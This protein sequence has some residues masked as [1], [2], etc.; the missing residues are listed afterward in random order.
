MTPDQYQQAK[1][2]REMAERNRDLTGE[3]A[4]GLPAQGWGCEEGMCVPARLQGRCLQG[5]C[6]P[7]PGAWLQRAARSMRCARRPRI[8]PAS[9]DSLARMVTTTNCPQLLPA[10]N[11]SPPLL[12]PQMRS[13][14]PAC[15][16]RLR[17]TRWCRH[18]PATWPSARRRARPWRRPRPLAP[19]HCTRWAAAGRLAV[20]RW[21][22]VNMGM[23]PGPG[24]ADH[25]QISSACAGVRAVALTTCMFAAACCSAHGSR[26]GPADARP[27][28]D[29]RHRR[30]RR[31]LCRSPPSWATSSSSRCPPS[32]RAC[33][34]SSRRTWP[35][36]A[37]S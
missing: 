36:L 5:A 37:S 33:P 19:R 8:H 26:R 16:G 31:H 27:A 12:Q 23:T 30:R 2:D 9:P 25:I 3:C 17:A 11:P 32:W 15:P 24:A 35:S 14:T 4:P 7:L 13:W 22:G 1:Y 29:R 6:R 10:L 28:A 21:P 20:G 34:T 18:P